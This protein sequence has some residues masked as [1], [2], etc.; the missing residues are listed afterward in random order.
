M[1]GKW[2][3]LKNIGT[4]LH[5]VETD[6]AG[7]DIVGNS[8]VGYTDNFFVFVTELRNKDTNASFYVVRQNMTSAK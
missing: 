6:M 3:E 2:F 5:S 4:F 1:T 7:S 8:S